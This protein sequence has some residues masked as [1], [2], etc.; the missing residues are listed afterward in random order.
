VKRF[1]RL[2]L[3]WLLLLA[4]P[5]QGFA[6][7][8]MPLCNAGGAPTQAAPAHAASHDHAAMLRAQAAGHHAVHAGAHDGAGPD[9]ASPGKHGAKTGAC[10]S[11][12]IGAALAPAL[13]VP[14]VPE[15][16]VSVPIPFFAGHLPSVDPVLPDRPPQAAL[17]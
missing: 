17:A 16:P 15:R 2:L 1:N 3:A 11:C 14:P 5:L 9:Q 12:C 8:R 13:P 6:G 4:L 10:A 7:A